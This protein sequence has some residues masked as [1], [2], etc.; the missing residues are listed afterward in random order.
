MRVLHVFSQTI[1]RLELFTA[2][3]TSNPC[4]CHVFGL[5]V[6]QDIPLV[7]TALPTH[8]AGPSPATRL[9]HVQLQ[10]SIKL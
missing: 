3:I 6:V 5:H 8:L 1:P 2:D 10:L 7:H 9:L 4:R